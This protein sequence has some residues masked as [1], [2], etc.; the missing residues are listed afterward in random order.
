MRSANDLPACSSMQ[1]GRANT[2]G[3]HNTCNTYCR[4]LLA[5]RQSG[6]RK[7]LSLK[8]NHEHSVFLSPELQALKTPMKKRDTFPVD[9]RQHIN[10]EKV[11]ANQHQLLNRTRGEAKTHTAIG[12]SRYHRLCQVSVR[13]QMRAT[14]TEGSKTC[15]QTVDR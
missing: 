13:Y 2:S 4:G 8:P 9:A 10:S 15:I 14:S 6:A 12:A 5:G 11:N 3:N 1:M 7:P